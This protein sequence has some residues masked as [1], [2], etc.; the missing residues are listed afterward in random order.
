MKIFIQLLFI[1][2]STIIHS[3]ITAQHIKGKIIEKQNQK[4]ISYATIK[5]F[6][7]NTGVLTDESGMFSIQLKFNYE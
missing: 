5:V 1:L 7:T 4:P 3:T 2:L 6:G